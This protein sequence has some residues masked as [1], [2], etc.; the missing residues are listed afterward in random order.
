MERIVFTKK[1]KKQ[2]NHA[3]DTI[4]ALKLREKKENMND[5]VRDMKN[6]SIPILEI[7]EALGKRRNLSAQPHCRLK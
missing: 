4:K 3:S 6:H 2:N 1:K 7:F 5:K